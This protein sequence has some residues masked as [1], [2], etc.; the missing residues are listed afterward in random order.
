MSRRLYTV[1]VTRE[2]EMVVC[3]ESDSAAADIAEDAF[4]EAWANS[5]DCADVFV[6]DYR[7]P[8]G[9]DESCLPYGD[10]DDRT[11]GDI[12]R[13]PATEHSPSVSSHGAAGRAGE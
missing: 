7:L 2:V 9:W 3:A 1:T 4:E 13:G 8:R 6:T 10:S 12:L 5:D 11:I